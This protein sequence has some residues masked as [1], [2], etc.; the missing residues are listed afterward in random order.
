MGKISGLVFNESDRFLIG[1]FLGPIAF[2]A[3]EVL[4]RLPRFL[5]TLV[6]FTSGA[7]LPAAS[8]LH[9]ANSLERLQRLY[10]LGI[11]LNL[12]F[13][14]PVISIS[15]LLAE[16]FLRAWVGPEYTQYALLL[17]LLFLWNISGMLTGFGGLFLVGTNTSL[18]EATYYSYAITALKIGILIVLLRPLG[19]VAVVLGTVVSTT[20]AL[21]GLLRLYHRALMLPPAA[22]VTP[23]LSLLW[24]L[25]LPI[26]VH[27]LTRSSGIASF[28]GLFLHAVVFCSL[29]WA[30]AYTVSLSRSERDTLIEI[31][32]TAGRPFRAA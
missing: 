8:Q 6:G 26:A 20:L 24:P 11:R 12:L 16:P 19:L 5:K 18:R 29:Y 4:F 15:A 7:L 23:V 28:P 21:P 2:A 3:Y 1:I 9:T 25:T 31:I 22:I 27:F 17:Q 30:L 13:F 32:R 14:L 10:M